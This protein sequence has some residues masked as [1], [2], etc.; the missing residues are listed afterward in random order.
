MKSLH[1]FLLIFFVS[2]T[3]CFAQLNYPLFKQAEETAVNDWLL[4][5]TDMPTK[6]YKTERN[7][8]VFANGL[9][10]RTF[11]IEPNCATIGLEHL[12]TNESFL[13]SV[14]PEAEIE[15]NGITFEVGGINGQPIHNYLLPKWM[16]NMK[17]NPAAFKL[18]DYR[19]ENTKERFPWKKKKEWM[20]RDLPWPAPGKELIFRY[21]L[22]SE[23]IN[24]LIDQNT[25]DAGRKVLFDDTFANLNKNW[26]RIESNKGDRNS[27]MNEGKAGEI[28]AL[29]NTSVYAELPIMQGTRVLLAKID[30]G[31]DKSNSWGPG[32]GLVFKDKVIKVNLRPGDNEFGFFNGQKEECIRGMKPDE[33]VWLRMES[34]DNKVVAFYSYNKKE[35]VKV[36]EV[37]VN[38]LVPQLVR[39]GKMDG[40]GKSSD[41]GTEGEYGRSRIEVFQMLGEVSQTFI[42]ADIKKYRYLEDIVVNVHYELY[43]GLPIFSKWITVEN[44]SSQAITINSFKSEILAVTEP[45]SIVDPVKKWILPNITV[46]TDYNFGGMSSENILNSSIAWKDDPLYLTQVN[47]ERKTPCLLEVYPKYGPEQTIKPNNVFSSYRVW[48]LLHDSWDRERKGLEQRRMMRAL[49]PWVTENPILMHVRSSD[50]ESVKKAIDQCVEVGFEMVIMTFGSGFN[51]EDNSTKNFERMKV[52]AEYAHSK[53]I[54]L[55]GYSLLAS[56]SIN[57]ENNVVMPEGMTPRFGNSPCL[58]SEWGKD[59]FDKLYQLYE[60]TNLD[61]LEHDGSYPGDVC[62]STVHPGHIGLEDSQWN[63]YRRISEFYQWCRSK[64]IYLNVPDYYFLVG[65]NKTGMGYRETNWSLPREQQEIIE[66]QNIYDG[67]W[68]KTPS[69]GWMF[70]PLVQ[71]H[72][73]GAAATI[74]PLKEHL[75]HYGQRLANLFGAGVQACY[76]GPQ[77]YDA[78]E[79][80]ELVKKW[81]NFYKKH[82]EVLDGD[83][84][85]LRRP[86]GRDWD[87]ILHVNPKSKEKGLLM[88]YNP[89]EKSITREI[90]IPVYYTGLHK[91]IILEDK[92]GNTQNLIVNRNYEITIK[93]TIPEKGYNFFVLK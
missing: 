33:A 44:N 77:L 90:K 28:F 17:V 74:E 48:E 73:G 36:G 52:L 69:M 18:V 51:A 64:G 59:Y 2:N 68:T 32:L 24:F 58:E 3:L 10:S 25:S 34:K 66:R 11:T 55:G 71:Y 35:W 63:Q 42:S 40:E 81:V 9:V 78:P 65:S 15:I 82:R 41:H 37:T 47:Y 54:A 1:F 13:R 49:A 89:L 20:P 6:L 86:D 92:V 29:S 62:A 67:T 85:H 46:E 19:V 22:G 75:P 80:K 4:S 84:I 88:L 23:S 12:Q 76:R 14:R 39:I 38:E 60:K 30:P 31:T 79:T 43:D 56:R 7:E 21:K 5:Q 53:G 57:A 91:S 70:V 72:G 8:L 27:F 26:K 87:G 50:D 83:I 93:V 61:I 45:E 16:E